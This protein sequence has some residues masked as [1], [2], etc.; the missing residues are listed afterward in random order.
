MR[1]DVRVIGE[2]QVER[3]G[4][5]LPLPASK[6]T[7]ALLGYLVATGRPQ[8]RERLCALLW[9]GPD[10]PRAA[11]RWSLTKIRPLLDDADAT[12]LEAD[13]ER[14]GFVALGAHVDLT[15]VRAALAGGVASASTESLRAAAVHLRGELLEGLDL[16]DCFRWD[17][18]CR[19]E[20]A[21][22]RKC[23]LAILAALVERLADAPEEALVYARARV[24]VDPVDEAGHV[25]VVRLLGALGRRSEAMKQYETCCRIL[26]SELSTRPSALLEQARMALAAAVP[27]AEA[28]APAAAPEAARVAVPAATAPPAQLVGRTQECATLRAFVAAPA[29]QVL[30]VLGD[31]GIGKTRLLEELATLVAAEGGTVLRGRAFEAEMV[32]PYGAWLDALRPLVGAGADDPFARADTGDRARL[33]EAVVQLLRGRATPGHKLALLIDD[34]QWIDEASAALLH[35][36]ARAAADAPVLLACG[37]RPGEL[38]DNPAAVRLVRTLGK[39]ARVQQIGLAPLDAADT[40]QLLLGARVDAGR[41]FAESG[42]NPLFA[43]EIARALARGHAGSES[44]EA[45]LRERLE[46]LD[47]GARGLVPWAAALGHG[48]SAEL[49]ARASGLGPAE[50]VSAIEELERRAVLRVV[51]SGYDFSHD[52]LRQ[53]A[54]RTLSEPRRCLVHMH[55]A[56]ALAA[57]PDADGALAGD[58][59]HHAAIGGDA[60]LCARACLSAGERCLRLYAFDEAAQLAERGLPHA[61]RLTGKPRAA[62]QMALL[63]LAVHAARDRGLRA[64]LQRALERAIVEAQASGCHAEV[65]HGLGTL[66]QIHFEAGDWASAHTGSI[67]VERQ[68]RAGEPLLAVRSLAHAAQCFALLEREIPHAEALAAEAAALAGQGGAEVTELPCALGLVRGYQGDDDAAGALLERSFALDRQAGD[69]WHESVC[70]SQLARIELLR[71][72][73]ASALQRSRALEELGTRMGDPAATAF[74]A[75]LSAV[76]GL[77]LDEPGA[78]GALAPA[79]QALR[80]ADAQA[81]L[82]FALVCAGQVAL[83][84]GQ[85][86]AARAHAEEA[87][88]AAATARRSSELVL[89]RSLAAE[90]A[91]A[92]GRGDDARAAV[93]A[94]LAL[95]GEG[96]GANAH[97]RG[98]LAA[99]AHAAGVPVP[100]SLHGAR[101]GGPCDG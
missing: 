18:W 40:A 70:L 99:V 61:A 28:P 65:A 46:Q 75:V 24:T 39:S 10:D 9:D 5:L 17:E 41:V 11:L 43:L 52:L 38:A 67:D 51:A 83:R 25:A 76:A 30:L 85:L 19:G 35:F 21:Q 89:A 48:F 50:G 54:Y 56:R 93:E 82:A 13:R 63:R 44:L 88:H 84:T 29:G 94:A 8:L 16:P 101:I 37:A 66:T 7:R 77:A 73:P 49:L 2:L 90:V 26:A 32:R 33:F 71:A 3:A 4:K 97:A 1:V 36:V 55:I 100:T 64:A 62:L 57:E 23:A 14:V 53:A 42:G 68:A 98:A 60:E 69:H 78:A 31:P 58:V 45:L 91:L 74:G 6:K 86:S 59:A 92:D 22:L 27:V 96:D 15:T 79:L 12:R 87:Q 72:R 20:R 34:I 47:E 95:L 81:M 80:S